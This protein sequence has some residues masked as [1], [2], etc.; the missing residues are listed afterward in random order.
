MTPEGAER[1]DRRSEVLNEALAKEV[2]RNVRRR[3]EAGI[4]AGEFGSTT[5]AERCADPISFRFE[6][7]AC[8]ESSDSGCEQ[9]Q[10]TVGKQPCSGRRV[11]NGCRE[12]RETNESISS[13]EPKTR[14]RIVTKPSTEESRMDDGGEEGDGFRSSTA[15]NTRR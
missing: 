2:E 11:K 1:L 9:W 8:K 3:D 10:I 14:R 6:K 15:T 7:E 4:A 5:R 12:R 13:T